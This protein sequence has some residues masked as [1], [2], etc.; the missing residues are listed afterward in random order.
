ML[1]SACSVSV[2]DS[3][4]DKAIK[5]EASFDQT[6][7]PIESSAGATALDAEGH[8]GARGS[9]GD[10]Q[11]GVPSAS[12][13][14]QGVGT[15]ELLPLPGPRLEREQAPR[16]SREVGRGGAVKLLGDTYSASGEER[17]SGEAAP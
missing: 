1:S 4:R 11:L 12:L 6:G 5:G 10:G 9:G 7:D 14:L 3:L 15:S 2:T 8:E 16:A 17:A 13:L